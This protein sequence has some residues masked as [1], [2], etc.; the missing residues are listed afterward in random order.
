[1]TGALM[2]D[3]CGPE[4]VADHSSRRLF[5]CGLCS[6][7]SSASIQCV[8]GSLHK[9]LHMELLLELHMEVHMKLH[10]ELHM[11]SY[12]APFWAD[13]RS[14]GMSI[15]PHQNDLPECNLRRMGKVTGHAD[16]V[17]IYIYRS[18]YVYIV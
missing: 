1:M 7:E 8:F 15:C 6:V 5:E 16:I 9:E 10:M 2:Y 18:T 14:P 17:H 13:R 12:G 3:M 4:Y 11:A